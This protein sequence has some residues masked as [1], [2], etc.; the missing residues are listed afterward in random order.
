MNLIFSYV[1]PSKSQK[2]LGPFNSTRLPCDGLRGDADEA[3][4]A[5]YHKH[6]WDVDGSDYFRLD[7]TSQV[8]LHFERAP[9]RSS[10]YGPYER[11]SAVNGLAYCDDQVV[12]ILDLKKSEWLYYDTGYHWPVMVVSDLTSVH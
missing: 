5:G 3:L 4:L 10:R 1:H 8:V 2:P 9:D 11:F 12:T 7:C 6:Q